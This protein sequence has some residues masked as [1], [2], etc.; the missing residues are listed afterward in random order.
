MELVS[1]PDVGGGFL[2]QLTRARAEPRATYTVHAQEG[3]L[4]GGVEAA[5]TPADVGF[6]LLPA[7][8]PIGGRRCYH[9]TFEVTVAEHARMRFAYNRMRF[10]IGPMLE[11]R[12]GRRAVPFAEGAA[13]ALARIAP[14]MAAAGAPWMVGGS[15]AAALGGAGIAPTDLDLLTDRDGV[16]RVAEALEEFLIEPPAITEWPNGG[17]R[18]AARAFVGTLT[19]G[20]RV[21]WAEPASDRAASG[22][23]AG[24][25]TA[26]TMARARS[27]RWRDLSVPV[28]PPEFALAT[29]LRRSDERRTAAILASR[30]ASAFDAE[31]LD[32]LLA[33]A[34]EARARGRA[35]L[36]S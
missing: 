28:A 19:E 13:T 1:G 31:R 20:L 30:P 14:A 9:R 8:C 33:D 32:T 7:M 12:A 3:G 10:V 15:G 22:D 26:A 2:F 16:D 34:P 25:W 24:E 11:Q 6:S 4:D 36:R 5:G 23:E 27:V 21:E 29:A 35:L 18:R 17:A